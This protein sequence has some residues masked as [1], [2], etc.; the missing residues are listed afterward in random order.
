MATGPDLATV[1][2][3][4][5]C[6]PS[7]R[8]D[9]GYTPRDRA[10][11]RTQGGV[12]MADAQ[13][14]RRIDELIRQLP[15][16][17]PFDLE[18]LCRE[19][20]RRWLDATVHLVPWDLSP[21][22]LCGLWILGTDHQQQQ[23]AFLVYDRAATGVHRD[24]VIGH[25]LGHAA[26]GHTGVDEHLQDLISQVLP[27]MPLSS[28]RGRAR[29]LTSEEGEAEYFGDRLCERI[30]L[31]RSRQ[32]KP[33]P[34]PSSLDVRAARVETV[35]GPAPEAVVLSWNVLELTVAGILW[36]FAGFK[37][38]E[39][40]R[41]PPG[42]ARP[43]KRALVGLVAFA[44]AALS[45][46][47]PPVTQAIDPLLLP[48]T[49][50]ASSNVIT[51]SAACSAQILLLCLTYG[52]P[53]ARRRTI[54]RAAILAVSVA[55]LVALFAV[56][57]PA[58]SASQP[59]PG[60]YVY[61][62]AAYATYTAAALMV[63]LWRYA[64]EPDPIEHPLIPPSMRIAAVGC[65]CALIYIAIK[66]V[67][68]AA[69]LTGLRL[70][71]DV[72]ISN[73]FWIV[74][75]LLV[76]FGVTAPGWGSYVRLDRMARLSWRHRTYRRMAPL[77]SLVQRAVPEAVAPRRE[78]STRFHRRVIEVADAARLLRPYLSNA[79]TEAITELIKRTPLSVAEQ[80]VHA[81][82]ARFALAAHRRIAAG[83]APPPH[84]IAA[85]SLLHPA[86]PSLDREADH[87]ARIA[88]A[89]SGPLVAQALAAQN[90]ASRA[91]RG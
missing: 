14:R 37:I 66:L 61:V 63:L 74:A 28:A 29:F 82:A 76:T 15:M 54:I 55:A 36:I 2:C 86:D 26:L 47:P 56:D 50:R 45:L 20:G 71:G 39:L 87:L 16:P 75:L 12:V 59:Y 67:Y 81:A 38:D 68:I 49:V 35:F 23:V 27:G 7:I 1:L 3:L 10:T 21:L 84:P 79:D 80:E 5:A 25:E 17:E 33:G 85:L 60:S 30:Q 13:L 6:H 8:T 22:A 19:A 44:A 43:A 62:Y 24:Q 40:R 51:M 69:H 78:R 57:H 70:P 72:N 41:V 77:W 46:Q 9:L 73:P 89:L 88:T 42:P 52:W 31:A 58:T 34:T 83:D 32:R 4:R 48:G 11:G 18:V 64:R 65:L 91:A 53:Q 90:G